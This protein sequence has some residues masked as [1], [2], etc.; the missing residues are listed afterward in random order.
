VKKDTKTELI[1][2]RVTPEEKTLIVEWG[3]DEPDL[4]SMPEAV[5]RMIKFAAKQKGKRR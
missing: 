1:T 3:K 4:P 5:R 2:I